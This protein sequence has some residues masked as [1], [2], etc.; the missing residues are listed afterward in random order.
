WRQRK[1]EFEEIETLLDIGECELSQGNLP[2]AAARLREVEQLINL[3]SEQGP[4]RH[5]RP[6][7]NQYRHNLNK[8]LDKKRT[9]SSGIHEV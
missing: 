3:T 1:V 5:L 2:Q 8:S 7:L 6:R 4:Y 9:T